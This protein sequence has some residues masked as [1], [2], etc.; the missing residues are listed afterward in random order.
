VTVPS[1]P[2]RHGDASLSTQ[3]EYSP[4][5]G[6]PRP[7]MQPAAQGPWP[8]QAGHRDSDSHIMAGGCHGH[9]DSDCRAAVRPACVWYK[10]YS[11]AARP[12]PRPG[13]LRQADSPAGPGPGL[14]ESHSGRQPNPAMNSA[15]GAGPGPRLPQA[16]LPAVGRPGPA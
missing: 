4:C 16:R 12:G 1:L 11:E 3:A 14:D 6:L 13:P 2:C 9:C 5:P 8:A 15:A 10:A 7:R